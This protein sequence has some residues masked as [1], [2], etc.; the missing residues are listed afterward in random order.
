[1]MMTSA[2]PLLNLTKKCRWA[3]REKQP[4]THVPSSS[5]SRSSIASSEI[6]SSQFSDK[7]R[8]GTRGTATTTRTEDQFD[9]ELN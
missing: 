8:I 1:M 6:E 2:L 7:N 9:V 5:S 3:E 4:S